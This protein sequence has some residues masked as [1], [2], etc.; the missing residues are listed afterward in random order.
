MQIRKGCI[1]RNG[2]N[3]ATMNFPKDYLRHLTEEAHFTHWY[4]QSI[5]VR[6]TILIKQGK[7]SLFI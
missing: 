3:N 6:R 5:G 2:H 7:A 1:P 4:L